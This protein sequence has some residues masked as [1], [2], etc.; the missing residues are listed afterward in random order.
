MVRGDGVRLYLPF[1]H[2]SP[3]LPDPVWKGGGGLVVVGEGGK[4]CKGGGV[5]TLTH[6]SS[7]TPSARSCHNAVWGGGGHERGEG[8]GSDYTYPFVIINPLC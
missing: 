2:I 7:S 3:I 8:R 6:S 5:N 1:H 4:V